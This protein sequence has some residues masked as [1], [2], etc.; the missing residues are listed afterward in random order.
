[1]SGALQNEFY[2][3]DIPQIL[4]GHLIRDWSSL[5]AIF[6]NE[7]WH[8][9]DL[10]ERANTVNVDTYRPF[11]NLFLLIDY[12][13]WGFSTV[14]FHLTNILIHLFNTILVFVFLHSVL[15]L[16]WAWLF[17]LLFSLHPLTLEPVHYVSA[18]SDSLAFMFGFAGMTLGLTAAQ[19]KWPRLLAVSFLFLCGACTKET[20]LIFPCLWFLFR[21]ILFGQQT[22]KQ[23]LVT[24]AAVVIPIAS[25]W[26]LRINALGQSKVFYDST[27]FFE[28]FLNYPFF[29]LDLF[30][31]VA[32]TKM[33]M[34]MQSFDVTR[35]LDDP[36]LWVVL[37]GTAAAILALA[38]A[39]WSKDKRQFLP[40]SWILLTPLPSFF[41]C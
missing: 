15:K 36:I 27:H 23:N 34:P 8:N 11:L 32:I 26:L 31:N 37:V 6:G 30:K 14:G 21:F 19:L 9:V 2:W 7:V 4:E 22:P 33:I 1:M 12:K 10:G 29:L 38:L 24:G 41:C 17:A 13:L 16:R 20:A 28:I 39:A 18:R 35:Q 5:P 3:D 40:L 25:Y